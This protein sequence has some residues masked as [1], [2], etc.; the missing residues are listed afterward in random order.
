MVTSPFPTNDPTG[1]ASAD[2]ARFEG[3]LNSSESQI[4]GSLNELQNEGMT[5]S[6]GRTEG[7]RVHHHSSDTERGVGYI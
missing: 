2:V 3:L 6:D 5:Y 1:G 7:Y 4:V